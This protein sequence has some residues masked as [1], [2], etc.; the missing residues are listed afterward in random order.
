MNFRLTYPVFFRNNITDS[1]VILGQWL[2][3]SYNATTEG[4][5]II[6]IIIITIIITAIVVVTI[7]IIITTIIHPRWYVYKA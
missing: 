4:K 7:Q 6:I 2:T 5:M 1:L 3:N